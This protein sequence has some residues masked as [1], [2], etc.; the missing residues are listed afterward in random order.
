L[1]QSTLKKTNF[2]SFI[3]C[4]LALEDHMLDGRA[5][6]SSPAFLAC[7]LQMP[8]TL[9]PLVPTPQSA[10]LLWLSYARLESFSGF[11]G[12][13]DDPAPG[14][15]VRRGFGIVKIRNRSFVGLCRIRIP[16]PVCREFFC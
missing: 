12:P 8:I 5:S 4:Q 2:N 9:F 1:F 10:I 14:F 16:A 15:E 7:M 3:F 11:L 6:S 13:G